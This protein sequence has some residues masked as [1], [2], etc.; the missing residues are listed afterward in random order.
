METSTILTNIQPI[1]QFDLWLLAQLQRNI[2]ELKSLLAYYLAFGAGN[3]PRVQY[4]KRAINQYQDQL[5]D[6]QIRTR[7]KGAA[8]ESNIANA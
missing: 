2:A 7:G 1:E 6:I 3:S 8:C 4:A 5:N